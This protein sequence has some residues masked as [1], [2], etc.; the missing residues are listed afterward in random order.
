MLLTNEVLA[1]GEQI[2]QEP[3]GT[4]ANAAPVTAPTTPAADPAS[5]GGLCLI[6]MQAH[7]HQPAHTYVCDG[8]CAMPDAAYV[9]AGDQVGREPASAEGN[10]ASV[11]APATP[12][13]FPAMAGEQG[14][15]LFTQLHLLLVLC[16]YA[17]HICTRVFEAMS[18]LI[19]SWRQT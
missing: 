12:A 15:M 19:N 8:G 13:A 1:A 10:A 11:A 7:L 14:C 6:A 18:C 16:C 3:A 2:E 5:A 4:D 9:A 17:S